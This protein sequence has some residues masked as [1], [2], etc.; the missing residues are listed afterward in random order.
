M[1]KLPILDEVQV[2]MGDK[3]E[4]VLSNE[5]KV[6]EIF[7]SFLEVIP[8]FSMEEWMEIMR[9]Y[10]ADETI[11]NVI[12]LKIYKVATMDLLIQFAKRHQWDLA[13]D[14]NKIYIY[15]KQLWIEIEA[16]LIKQFLKLA[17][18]KLG[19]PRWVASD[20]N[21]IDD[22]F[23]Q[24]LCASFFEKM[25]HR[26]KTLINL[27][28]GTLHIDANGFRLEAFNKQD[29][30]THQMD[31]EYD[32]SAV[33]EQ[34]QSFLDEVLPNADTQKTLQQSLAYLFTKDLK[35][36][37]AIFL[38]GTG[39]NGK[40]VVFEVLQGMIPKELMTNYSLESLAQSTGYHRVGIHNKLV[41]YGTDI[42]MKKIEHG[43]FKQ[44]VSGEP[45]E[46]RQIY[47]KPFIMKNY[48]K[49]IFNLNKIDDADVESTIGFFRRMVFVPFEKTIK[50]EQ[51]DKNLHKKILENKAGVLNWILQGLFE[52]ISNNEIFISKSCN[53]FLE[54]FRKE[55][56]ISLR[57]V[58]HENLR[59]SDTETIS[60]QTIYE[61]FR[62]YCKNQGEA[63]LT[64]RVFNSEL[65]KLGFKSTRRSNGFVWFA[66]HQ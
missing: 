56:N 14:G 3:Q 51:Q 41:N 42:S 66:H 60:F 40:S 21:F 45:L 64:Q 24:L 25:E 16:D 35:L 8:T 30:L 55:S 32:E 29:F 17:T 28:N 31:F 34:W 9:K 44:L 38:Y 10:G 54:N 39:S 23:K 63:I 53:S 1:S 13:K 5:Q 65:K 46:A 15:D 4:F 57:F 19:L 6:K 26:N 61:R 12:H 62:I 27:Q 20:S 52:V 22:M 36:E 58:E 37:K 47:E 48:A 49:L 2:Q 33:N 43:I 18:I 11:G 50:P 59:T 7:N